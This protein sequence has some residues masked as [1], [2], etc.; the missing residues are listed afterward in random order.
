M[1]SKIEGYKKNSQYLRGRLAEELSDQSQP[2][3]SEET[4][5]LLKFHGVYAQDDRD[6]RRQRQRARE[7]LAHSF[8]ARLALPGGR[9]GAA[10]YLA[11][12]DIMNQ[13]EL[14]SLRL[15]SRQSIQLHGIEKPHLR[16]TLKNLNHSLVST[17]AGCGDVERN[18]M[19]CPVPS[20]DPLRQDLEHWTAVLSATLRPQT[21][22]YAELW[23]D[24]D[25]AWSSAEAEDV[26]PLYGPTYLPRKFKT[27]IALEGDN[28]VDI[29]SQDLGLVAHPG[30]DGTID[31]FTVLVGGGL[32][33]SHGVEATHAR[34]AEPLATVSAGQVVALATA[35][36]TVQRDFG[37]REDRR[38]ARLKYLV[39]KW[40]L[41]RFQATVRER[42]D[43]DLDRPRPLHF[44]PLDDHLG[45]HPVDSQTGYIGLHVANGRIQDSGPVRVRTGLRRLIERYQ[46]EIVITPQQNLILT[47]LP[48]DCESQVHALLT[49]FDI[50][51]PSS[52]MVRMAMACPA[53]P[54]CGLAITESERVFGDVLAKIQAIWESL[55]MGQRP[56]QVRMT[57]C[58]NN[59][60]RSF[61]AEIGFVGRSLNSYTVYVG[62][63]DN[64]TQLN[65][66]YAE[67]IKLEHLVDTVQPLLE[68]YAEEHQAEE[69]FG[70]FCQRLV[71]P[72]LV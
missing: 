10:Q 53:L 62:G 51:V 25:K 14:P 24:G 26:E 45:W 39:E 54:T 27:A 23:I 16:D 1:A 65:R 41:S 8:M 70:E 22:A 72:A 20:R 33:K 44:G 68:H 36:V 55:G 42:L 50:A 13:L 63:R 66:L 6:L 64:G 69:S 17:L 37:N 3:V 35:I 21:R 5:Q 71:L 67:N 49:Q 47:G 18:L 56:L 19:C 30:R 40:G 43:F 59:C 57:G 60:A 38:Y 28:C 31:A 46:P 4:R 52:P 12:D 15:T 34:L 9:L 58:P 48:L 2:T 32:A 61:M 7:P 11:I 29:F